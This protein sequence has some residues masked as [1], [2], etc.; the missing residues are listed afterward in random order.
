MSA[1]NDSLH[2]TLKALMGAIEQA[3]GDALRTHLEELDRQRDSLGA[4][5]PAQLRHF[6]EKRS[7]AK[8]I[9]FLEGRDESIEGHGGAPVPNC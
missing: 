5:A 4:D 2:A 3:D 8:A 6:L 1:A 9:D 7:Y